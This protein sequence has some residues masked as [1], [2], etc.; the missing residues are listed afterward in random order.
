MACRRVPK[1]AASTI[2]NE[3]SSNVRCN[4]P[5]LLVDDAGIQPFRL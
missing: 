5:L 4:E 3:G 2:W 1:Y